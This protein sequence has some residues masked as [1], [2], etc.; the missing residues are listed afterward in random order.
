MIV[1][2][3][4]VLFCQLPEFAVGFSS[5]L[6]FA[7]NAR[8][9]IGH[10]LDPPKLFTP[11]EEIVNTRIPSKRG[12]DI[13]AFIAE[14]EHDSG[15]TRLLLPNLLL[16]HEFFGLNESIQDKAK[17]LANDLGCRVI[18]PDTF[19]GISTD[20][21]PRAIWLSLSTSQDQ[22]NDDLDDVCAYLE[23]QG[24][25]EESSSPELAI[26]GFCYGGG[27]AIRYAIER[28]PDAAVVVF[29]GSPVTEESSLRKLRSPVCG[30][31]GKDD[32][33]FPMPL[34]DKFQSALQAAKVKN[35]IQIYDGVGHAFWK[36]MQQI[37]RGDEPQ[38]S[39]YR[40]CTTFLREFFFASPSS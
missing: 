22:V 19:R 29:Y 40:R 28:K 3:A 10:I 18:A 39:A 7:S 1:V 32:F 37:H 13:L 27:K 35:N 8:H 4:A 6:S 33:Q 15:R 12:D 9:T 25:I 26:M 23:R 2:V 20:F 11:L 36:D 34:L 21:I 24:W 17:G 30:I 38:T 16:I 5:L 31:Y 14:P